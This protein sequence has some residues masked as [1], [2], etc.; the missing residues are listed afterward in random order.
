MIHT[1][2]YHIKTRQDYECAIKSQSAQLPVY[3]NLTYN[4]W[5]PGNASEPEKCTNG[6]EQSS[7]PEF[8][9]TE[10]QQGVLKVCIPEGF[11]LIVILYPSTVHVPHA[12]WILGTKDNAAVDEIHAMLKVNWLCNDRRNTTSKIHSSPT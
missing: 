12:T 8:I 6:D 9:E 1:W 5:R 10:A 3:L 2:T 11:D 4:F 7:L